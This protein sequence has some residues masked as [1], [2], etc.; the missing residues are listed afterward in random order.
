MGFFFL[1]LTALESLH[2]HPCT[3]GVA[4]VY[5][6]GFTDEL[7][8]STNTAI[9]IYTCFSESWKLPVSDKIPTTITGIQQQKSVKMMKAT[10]FARADSRFTFVDLIELDDLTADKNIAK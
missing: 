1:P 2:S 8:G 9:H 3:W 4:I 6:I 7:T 10:R 5:S